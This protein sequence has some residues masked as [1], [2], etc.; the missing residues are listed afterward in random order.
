M[1]S[2]EIRKSILHQQIS[3]A[4]QELKDLW[5]EERIEK[6]REVIGK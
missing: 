1:T 2:R 3:N 5:N 6:N 4:Q